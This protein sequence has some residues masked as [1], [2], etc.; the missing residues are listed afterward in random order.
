MKIKRGRHRIVLTFKRIVIK[1]PRV[2]FKD[3]M[4]NL[5][6]ELKHPQLFKYYRNT[7]LHD[8][9]SKT[10]LFGGLIC[11][12]QERSF[13]SRTKLAILAPTYFSL[14]G[15]LNIQK[16]GQPIKIHDKD[17]LGQLIE[18]T[19]KGVYSDPHTF[20]NP[21]NFCILQ[22]KISIVD[23]PLKTHRVLLDYGDKIQEK[24]DL[25]CDFWSKGN[26]HVET[27]RS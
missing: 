8:G 2:Y 24:F 26:L 22:G 18:I 4:A 10:S 27:K 12:W 5:L 13:Y 15:L 7:V 23:Y 19:D 14:F 20:E 11:N 1:I 3:G 6:L 9:T 17:L 25:S 16:M 21:D